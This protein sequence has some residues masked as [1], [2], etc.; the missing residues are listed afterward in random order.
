MSVVDFDEDYAR[1]GRSRRCSLIHLAPSGMYEP[2]SSR[3]QVQS[4]SKM[5]MQMPL[6]SE[7]PVAYQAAVR[8]VKL[9][10]ARTSER[11]GDRGIGKMDRDRLVDEGVF[12]GVEAKPNLCSYRSCCELSLMR[13]RSLLTHY[14]IPFIL[15]SFTYSHNLPRVPYIDNT[16]DTLRHSTSSPANPAASDFLHRPKR[17]PEQGKQWIEG[18]QGQL[19]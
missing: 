18:R 7:A 16:A 13:E 4:E 19:T 11:N 14:N 6:W 12:M 10:N 8:A 3:W 9:Y 15:T 17:R 2:P 5:K 1:R